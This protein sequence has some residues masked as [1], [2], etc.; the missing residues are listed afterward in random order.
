VRTIEE[1]L[2]AALALAAP[3]PVVDVALDEALGHVLARNL[4]APDSLPRWEVAAVDGYAVRAQDTLGAR[5]DSPCAL[6]IQAGLAAGVR[7]EPVVAPG[8]ATWVVGGA[9][10]PPGADAIVPAER[11]DGGVAVVLVRTAA[12]PGMHVRRVGEGARAGDVVLAAGTVFGPQQVGAAAG[13]GASHVAVHRRPRVAV[14]STAGELVPP[15]ETLHRGQTPDT[16]SYLLAAAVR[17]AGGEPVRIGVVAGDAASL[18][19][20]LDAQLGH[21]DAFVTTGEVSSSAYDVGKAV[22]SAEPGMVFVSVAMTPG[23]PQGLGTLGDGTPVF[24]LPGNPV[25]AFVSFEVFV[26]PALLRMRGL[27]DVSRP[28]LNAVVVDGWRSPAGRAQYVPVML[29]RADD[30]RA[31]DGWF[32]PDSFGDGW[33]V[34]QAV[35]S[36]SGSHLVAG[37]GGAE[38]L[39]VIPSDIIDVAPGDTVRVMLVNR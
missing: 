21:V 33:T 24:C 34:R 18:R 4:E 13:I 6:T 19:R 28:R 26:R 15:G 30:E 8:T 23:R 22:L 39:A 35:R 12:V 16:N 20:V 27:R 31:F 5:V 7:E 3:L 11:A 25:S 10:L 1:H 38:A 14:L 9:P 17:E 2:A 37:L 32:V 29:E 36:G